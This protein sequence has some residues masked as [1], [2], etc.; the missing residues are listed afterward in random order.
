MSRAKLDHLVVE[1][2]ADLELDQRRGPVGNHVAGVLQHAARHHDQGDGGDRHDQVGRACP[3]KDLGK[4][5]A[6]QGEP[7]D[8]DGGGK[9]AERHHGGDPRPNAGGERPQSSVEIHAPLPIRP[10]GR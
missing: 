3:L 1:P 2:L 6:E 4:Q 5:P 7:G 10:A 9:Q 8:A